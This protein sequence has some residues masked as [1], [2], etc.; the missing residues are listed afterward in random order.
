MN[1]LATLRAAVVGLA[2]ALGAGAA[3]AAE[4]NYLKEGYG[5]SGYDPVAYFTVGAPTL[6]DDAHTSEHEGVTYR[7]ASA[8]HKATF[9]A[10][11]AAYVP[12][13]GGFCAFG[14][15]MGRKF[16]GDPEQ[17]TIEN[18]TLYVNL[19]AKI[20]ERWSAN[21]PGFIKGADNNWPLIRS[22]PDADLE[23]GAGPDGVTQGAL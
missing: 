1:I 2:V 4:E 12:A 22:V 8:E 9:D 11:P 21:I 13:Y 3:I 7:F 10:D 14:T 19:N 17:W 23:A 20:K 16:P 5:L 6:G 15:A 18:G